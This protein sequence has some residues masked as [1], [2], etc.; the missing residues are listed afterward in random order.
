MEKHQD[1]QRGISL[2]KT[3]VTS[4]TAYYYN[5]LG[6]DVP[7]NLSTFDAF[8]KLLHMLSS[9]KALRA[10]L[11]SNIASRSEKQAQQLNRSIWKASSAISADSSFMDSMHTAIMPSSLDN[12]LL[13]SNGSFLYT[14]KLVKHGGVPDS[15]FDGWDLVEREVLPP[16]PSQVEDVAQWERAMSAGAKRK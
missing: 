8:A 15:I 3:S 16:P 10:A 14:G 13:N 6:L 4:I 9:S 12:L 7:S 1:L 5:S 11:E 2:L